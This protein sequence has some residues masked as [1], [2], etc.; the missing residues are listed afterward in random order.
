MQIGF[1]SVTCLGHALIIAGIKSDPE[2]IAAIKQLKAPNSKS[3]L[4]TKTGID[5]DV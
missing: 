1:Y 3:E 4:E 5:Q 2:K